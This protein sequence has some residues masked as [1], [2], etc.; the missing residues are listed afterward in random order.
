VLHLQ[1]ISK[2]QNVLL[3][4]EDYRDQQVLVDT[5]TGKVQDIG[6]FPFQITEAIS[7]DG[8][9]LL[10]DTYVTGATS[11]YNLY[12][13]RTDG[14]SPAMIGH[15]AGI[16]LSFDGKWALALDPA[17]V[18]HLR[19][20]P[21]GIGEARTLNAPEGQGYLS[22]TRMPDG[23]HVLIDVAA[24]GHAPASYLQDVATGTVSRVTSEGRYATTNDDHLM[25]VSPDG[26]YAITT[27]GENHYWLQ[28]LDKSE[29]SEVKGLSE[30]DR[31]LQWHN[32][33][34]NIFFE[35]PVGTDTIEIYDLDLATGESKLWTRFSPS[36]KAAMIAI[37]H[38]LITPDGAHVL[39][40]VQRIYST[41]FV[42]KG[43]Q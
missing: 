9:V 15:G 35:R 30:G 39:Y 16:A 27:D 37:R 22:A 5:A 4:V 33:S 7:R 19:I 24:P 40:V 34:Q 2:D 3:T 12:T 41:L 26:K 20:I 43:I 8:R 42:A 28:P 23:K 10:F 14:S 1:D 32:D 38:P 17:N 13:Q 29:A 31:P 18:G 6:A 21:T 36:D 11:D 25:D